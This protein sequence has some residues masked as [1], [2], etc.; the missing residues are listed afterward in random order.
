M[1][2][3]E[4]I[5][6]ETEDN[7]SLALTVNLTERCNNLCLNCPNDD[8][9][10]SRHI[11]SAVIIDF[12]RKNL[13]AKHQR[14]GLIGGEPTISPGL[15][16]VL[17]VI[18]T[19]NRNAIIQINTNGRMLSYPL[20]AKKLSK[21]EKLDMHI[22]LYGSNAR[23][24][25]RITQCPG[26]FRQTVAG[27][28]ECLSMGMCLKLRSVLSRINYRDLT[29]YARFVLKEFGNRLHLIEQVELVAMDIIGEAK[30]NCA[31]L[32]VSFTELA[33]EMEKCIDSF[34]D[35]G[36]K[37]FLHLL[38]VGFLRK[39]YFRHAGRTGCVDGAFTK[40]KGCGSCIFYE[41]CPRMLKS[42]TEIF[43]TGEHEPI[44]TC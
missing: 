6:W 26:S 3:I 31:E 32:A 34:G 7:G 36:T 25:D 29:E 28:H 35:S 9:F 12:L 39:K 40:S 42:Y 5:V 44:L 8:N 41:Q 19:K 30:K 17:D 4:N 38:P 16:K 24:H 27:I 23:V 1:A 15:F 33:P 10:R 11:D 13:S 14:I 43:G 22:A 37:V 21:Y 20:F 2:E 18:K